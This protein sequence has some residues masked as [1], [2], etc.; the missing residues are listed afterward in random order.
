MNARNLV[1]LSIILAALVSHSGQSWAESWRQDWAARVSTEYDTNPAMIPANQEGVRRSLF[2]PSYKLIR[3]GGANELN[4]GLAFQFARS[5]NKTLSQDRD[6]PSV[7]LDY[8]R[9]NVAGEIAMSAKYN[10]VST[11]A[12]EIESSGIGIVDSTRATRTMS[13]SLKEAL[14]ERS[15]LTLDGTYNNVFYKGGTL[16]DYVTRS[17]SM[18]FS[19]DWSE[20][21]VPF[22]T[23][24]YSKYEPTESDT[25]SRYAHAILGCNWK[26]S[27]YLTGS[28]Q[29]GRSKISGP[30]MGK[31][32][33]AAVQ[34]T[35]QTTVLA[36]NA[37][38]QVSA[39]GMG[40]FITVDQVN[41][42][43]SYALGERSKSGIDL[44]WRKNRFVTRFFNRTSGAW[45][46]YEFDSF[47][48]MRT[49]YTH[50][51]SEQ[52]GGGEASS[53]MIGLTLVYTHTD[54]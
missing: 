40:G 38:R 43:W 42:S 47:W 36:L 28:L 13:A 37:G 26:V 30:R 45:L 11:R 27:D 5:S 33:S 50:K 2:E 31:Q 1:R 4:A 24:S 14:S 49:Y 17:A 46:Q 7:F 34:Y 20:V 48:L 22:I 54:F 51:I 41:G 21:S 52:S 25:Y 6:D 18:K 10:E 53:D 8:R 29:F 15:T 19:Y 23:M 32:G 44:G 9:Q 3:A 39:S 16:V 12:A 35:G